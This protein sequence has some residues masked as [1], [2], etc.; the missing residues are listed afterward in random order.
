MKIKEKAAIIVRNLR[1]S[2]I[3]KKEDSV[4][5]LLGKDG[6]CSISI[7]I[8]KHLQDKE[9]IAIALEREFPESLF[10]VKKETNAF[11][12]LIFKIKER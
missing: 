3:I 4:F 5:F 1:D 9:K 2:G 12:N 6:S 7:E 8:K 10:D 11:G